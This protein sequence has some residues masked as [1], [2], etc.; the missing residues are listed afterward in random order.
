MMML[1]TETKDKTLSWVTL[2]T[3]MRKTQSR[4]SCIISATL[5]IL[6]MP[7]STS[8]MVVKGTTS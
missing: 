7:A 4:R 1:L 5:I 6:N 2:D 8:S 3:T